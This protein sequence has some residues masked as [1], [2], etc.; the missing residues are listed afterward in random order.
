MAAAHTRF[1]TESSLKGPQAMELLDEAVSLVRKTPLAILSVYYLGAIPYCLM[2]IYFWFDM[3]QSVDAEAHLAV[4]TLAL[5]GAYFWMKIFQ[6]IFSRQLLVLLEGGRDDPWTFRRWI[7][8]AL[9]Q[10]VYGGSLVI[11]YP[12]SILVGIPFAW[13][14]GFYHNVSII[15]AEPQSTL[16]STFKEATELAQ[17]WPKQN[18][19]LIGIQLIAS[20]A[21]FLNLGI[22]FTTLPQL[23]NMFFGI[24][25]VFTE[26]ESTW[27]NSSF[28]LDVFIFCYLIINPINKAIYALRC[29]YGRARINGADIDAA[30]QHLQIVRNP[31]AAIRSS[32]LVLV[33]LLLCPCAR[34]DE[35]PAST[36]LLV[37]SARHIDPTAEKLNQAIEST[38]RKDEFSWRLPRPAT[39]MEQD[40]II[41]R[42]FRSFQHFL[43]DS[44]EGLFK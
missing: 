26:N 16:A 19:L 1:S 6:A 32:A 15:G 20:T 12:L 41:L 14:N 17:L 42:T 35:N 43:K 18:H 11:V 36:P 3:S 7:N 8:T 40:G 30:L 24:E 33:L 44:T 27:N 22:F 4:E 23:L 28:Y 29:F 38:L 25:T 10:I 2:L 21:L 9:I 34:A 39:N 37:T 13:V 5:T 31:L